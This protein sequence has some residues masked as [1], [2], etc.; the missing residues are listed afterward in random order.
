MFY[1]RVLVDFM[2]SKVFI[3]GVLFNGLEVLIRLIVVLFIFDSFIS[4][5]VYIIFYLLRYDYYVFRI[6]LGFSRIFIEVGEVFLLWE[7]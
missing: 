2:F 1:I 4:N 3:L 5:L 6:F 7:Y